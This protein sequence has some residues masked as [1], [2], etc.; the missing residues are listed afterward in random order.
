MNDLEAPKI[1]VQFSDTTKALRSFYALLSVCEPFTHDEDIFTFEHDDFG[2]LV[3]LL[4]VN[5]I[6]MHIKDGEAITEYYS[7]NLTNDD[8]HNRVYWFIQ[9]CLWKLEEVEWDSKEKVT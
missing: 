5:T 4:E 2:K 6:E 3:V 9:K 7:S 1:S 8:M